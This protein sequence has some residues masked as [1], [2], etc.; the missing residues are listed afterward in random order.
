MDSTDRFLTRAEVERRTGLGRSMIYRQMRA[1]EFPSGFKVG[2]S[3]V[4]WSA[5]EVERWCESRPRSRGDEVNPTAA[6]GA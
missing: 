3:A 5:F 4:R 1:G 6:R 2:P